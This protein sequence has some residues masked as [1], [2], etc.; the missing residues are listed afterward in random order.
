MS[1]GT[2]QR[3]ARFRKPQVPFKLPGALR[4]T[5]LRAIVLTA[6]AILASIWA[7]HR[8]YTRT[9]APMY[10]PVPTEIPAPELLPEPEPAPSAPK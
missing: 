9:P 7:I 4:M 3:K 1:L 5:L 6:S 8:Y 2:R 10:R